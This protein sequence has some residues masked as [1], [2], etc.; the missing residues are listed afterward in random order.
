MSVFFFYSGQFRIKADSIQPSVCSLTDQSLHAPKPV[1]NKSILTSHQQL[2]TTCPVCQILVNKSTG[3]EPIRR[4]KI[5]AEVSVPP[6]ATDFF[7]YS[8]K[9]RNCRMK[10]EKQLQ[11]SDAMPECKHSLRISRNL[12]QATSVTLLP[13]FPGLSN[14]TGCLKQAGSNANT[15]TVANRFYPLQTIIKKAADM[16][17][18]AANVKCYNCCYLIILIAL[19]VPSVYLTTFMHM[20]FVVSSRKMRRPDKS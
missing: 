16:C 14:P 13:I 4:N 12:R 1:S 5:A 11:E 2:T 10:P 9:C 17:M 18:P 19:L 6:A 20:P 7:R 8:I 3:L 15:R